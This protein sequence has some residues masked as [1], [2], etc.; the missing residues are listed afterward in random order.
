MIVKKKKRTYIYIYGSHRKR[1][2]ETQL[3]SARCRQGKVS[4]ICKGRCAHHLHTPACLFHRAVEKKKKVL[5]KSLAALVFTVHSHS[6]VP[7]S[8]A[9]TRAVITT[10][11]KAKK[12]KKTK[13]GLQ[14]K[15]QQLR[16]RRKKVKKTSPSL[17]LSVTIRACASTLSQE[18]THTHTH[19][20]KKKNSA[21]TP[22]Q[23]LVITSGK[24]ESC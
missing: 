21:R 5:I 20:K 10:L 18:D 19:T 14:P 13:D 12:K 22:L 17:S 2:L 7:L 8:A 11:H 15:Q 24:R 16:T 23:T 3:L 9:G 6:V 1:K 4:T